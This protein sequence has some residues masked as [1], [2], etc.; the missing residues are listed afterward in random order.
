MTVLKSE[1]MTATE[2]IEA[3]QAT[4]RNNHL[5]LNEVGVVFAH[6]AGDYWR[7][8]IADAITEAEYDDVEYSEYHRRLVIEDD[9]DGNTPRQKVIVLK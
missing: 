7:T 4:C 3:I 9:N 1:T 5:N 8:T 6:S 2:V